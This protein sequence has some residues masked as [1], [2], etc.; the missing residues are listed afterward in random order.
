MS[1]L[2]GAIT[3]RDTVFDNNETLQFEGARGVHTL[4]VGERTFVYVAG[5]FDAGVSIFELG[6]DGS[7]THV[8]DVRDADAPEL[9]LYATSHFASATVGGVTYLFVNSSGAQTFDEIDSAESGISAFSV[10]ADG[11][12]TNVDN[13]SDSST[14]DDLELYQASGKMSVATVGDSYFLIAS[15]YVDNG[16]SVFRIN[17]DGTLTNTVNIDGIEFPRDMASASVGDHTFIFGSWGGHSATDSGVSVHEL[18]ADG[19]TDLRDRV[20]D[21]EAA[22]G[23]EP[24][25]AETRGLATAKVDGITY[26]I[27]SGYLDSGLNV[28]SVDDTGELT[29]VYILGDD[30]GSEPQTRFLSGPFGLTT[31]MLDGETFVAVSAEFDNALGIYHLGAGGV[32]TEVTTVF[33]NADLR[34]GGTRYNDFAE[35][36]GTPLLV[37]TGFADN[38]LSAFDIGSGDDTLLGSGNDDLLLGL[39]GNDVLDGQGGRDRLLGGTG[40]DTYRVYSAGD[41]V[42]ER[43]DA[44][45]DTV[46]ASINY[47]LGAHVENLVLRASGDILGT[48]NDLDNALIG[49]NGRNGLAGLAGQDT[50][51][52]LKGDD[53]LHG[54]AG[55]DRLEG[56]EGADDLYG[57]RGKDWL[58]GNGG[59][60]DFIFTTLKDSGRAPAKRDIIEGFGDKDRL[61]LHS[62]DAKRGQNGN[63]A[64]ELDHDGP[65]SAGEIRVREVKA[66]LLVDLNVDADARAEFA[67]LLRDLDGSMNDRDF[68]L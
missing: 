20:V 32:L 61:D 22:D 21:Q 43:A 7:L 9:K 42:V 44:G 13:V 52:G 11:T 37:A 49:N 55:A 59:A 34:I 39:G 63:Q 47:S 28:F 46:Q 31:F 29:T 27:A 26:L 1:V 56:S 54:G 30:S 65:F 66:G 8:D 18:N 5:R 4:T 41:E 14:T 19:T 25:L 51:V 33:D 58:E 15:G 23:N 16:F 50:L 36:G 60:D 67:V 35:V 17:T 45:T 57:G 3:P 64:F 6:S 24:E 10:N 53:T 48:G 2:I 40:N 68:V 38:G 62:I 12:L